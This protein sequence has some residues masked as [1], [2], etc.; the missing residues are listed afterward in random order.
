M[1]LSGMSDMPETHTHHLQHSKPLKHLESDD[2]SVT[3]DWNYCNKDELDNDDYQL[4][5]SLGHS[6]K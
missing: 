3:Y 1:R 2:G 6:D 5:N 4:Y